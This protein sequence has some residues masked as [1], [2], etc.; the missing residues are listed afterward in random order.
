MH[1]G[2]TKRLV[3]YVLPSN[4]HVLVHVRFV[5]KFSP[6]PMG[7]DVLQHPAEERGRNNSEETVSS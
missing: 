2:R 3:Q 1:I 6:I 5:E 7:K 4:H